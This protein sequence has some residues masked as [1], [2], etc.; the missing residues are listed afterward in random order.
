M[1]ANLNAKRKRNLLIGVFVIIVLA[2]MVLLAGY[3]MKH[4][5]KETGGDIT[6]TPTVE[7]VEP[8]KEPEVPH[9]HVWEKREIF[10][11]CTTDGYAYEV[12]WCGERQ[13]EV[14]VNA[15]GHVELIS[16]IVKH[17][18]AEEEGEYTET[19]KLC[20]K[21]V[22]RGIVAKLTPTPTPEPTPE[23]TETPHEHEWVKREEPA[24][25]SKEGRTWEECE[26][27]KVQNDVLVEKE[28]HKKC[29][30][31]VIEQ[32]TVE[33]EGWFETVCDICG[34][35]VKSGV[36]PKLTPTPKP[37]AAPTPKP[38]NI[39]KPTA[40]PTP[41]PTATPKPVQVTPTPIPEGKEVVETIVEEVKNSNGSTITY[42]YD[43]LED[44]TK[45]YDSTEEFNEK[46]NH[47]FLYYKEYY[48]EGGGALFHE[49]LEREVFEITNPETKETYTGVCYIY[50]RDEKQPDES[51]EGYSILVN[52]DGSFNQ[53]SS[54]KMGYMAGWNSAGFGYTVDP[55]THML[56]PHL[57]LI[58]FGNREVLIYE[59]E[60]PWVDDHTIVFDFK[61]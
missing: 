29:T 49:Y 42:K 30:Y 6:P 61:K 57:D 52:S 35:V 31:K 1:D 20:G 60:I 13:N 9:E 44:G 4:H 48:A 50:G 12:C 38:T 10:A 27:G 37:T 56:I 33:K 28:P 23:P 24:T 46:Y 45:V 21:V 40:T 32:P 19:C 58:T 16:T 53:Y 59:D 25:C 39:P 54:I 3:Y 14:I 41:K 7:A 26:C 22:E 36:V 55:E 51:W 34:T 5:G 8:T 11:T 2:I 43:I 15:L 18:T 47:E 17:P